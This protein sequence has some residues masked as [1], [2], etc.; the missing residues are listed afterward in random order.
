MAIL[1]HLIR[2]AVLGF[3]Q[4]SGTSG[5]RFGREVLRDPGFVA[6]LKAGRRLGLKTADAVLAAIGEAPV[7]PAFAREV[8]AFLEA[9]G[10][11]AYVLGYEAA[12]DVSFVNRL[13]QGVSFRLETVEKVRTWMEAHADDA[14]RAAMRRA[15]ADT[16]LL[17]R[18]SSS[19]RHG[20][21]DM[22]D[23]RHLSAKEAAAWL[24]ISLRTLY[25]LRDEGGGPDHYRFGHRIL[26]RLPALERW[27]AERLVTS[28]DAGGR[29]AP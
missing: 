5:R 20:E 27:A 21:T 8:E 4:R 29:G 15:V 18:G 1:D 17:A 25:R 26:Y 28:P 12:G 6:S 19:E 9:G 23:N 24:G 11:K 14:S 22:N 13:R 16:P 7:G 10:C 3:L 2:D